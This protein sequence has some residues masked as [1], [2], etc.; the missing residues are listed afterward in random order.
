MTNKWKRFWMGVAIG[1]PIGFMLGCSSQGTLNA[2]SIKPATGLVVDRYIGYVENDPTLSDAEK[3]KRKQTGL[4]LKDVVFD[5]A[6][7][8]EVVQ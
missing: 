3:L 1:A 8:D 2:N 4:L 6:A 7:P 5:A